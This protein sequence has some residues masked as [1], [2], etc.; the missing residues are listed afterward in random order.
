MSVN[1]GFLAD[2]KYISQEQETEI[3]KIDDTEEGKRRKRDC[4]G[5]YV[6]S[7]NEKMVNFEVSVRHR[8]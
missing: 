5:A 4:P 2:A 7:W 6:T 1:R 8:K 3:R